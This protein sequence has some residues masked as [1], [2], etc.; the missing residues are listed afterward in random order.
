MRARCV[1]RI[2]TLSFRVV[3]YAVTRMELMLRALLSEKKLGFP[4]S[5]ICV[6]DKTRAYFRSHVWMLNVLF[7]G[8]VRNHQF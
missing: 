6:S 3:A 5:I 8:S 2:C 1:C 4:L 7:P